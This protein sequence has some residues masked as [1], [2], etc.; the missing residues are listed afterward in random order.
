MTPSED[1]LKP[2]NAKLLKEMMKAYND[3]ETESIKAEQ[4]IMREVLEEKAK[5]EGANK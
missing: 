2:E 3:L 4:E 5:R 1:M